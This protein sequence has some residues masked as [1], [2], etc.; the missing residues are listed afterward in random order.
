[1]LQI[2]CAINLESFVGE[3]NQ[4]FTI[5]KRFRLSPDFKALNVYRKFMFNNL[6]RVKINVSNINDLLSDIVRLWN[7]K[8]THY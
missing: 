2:D 7:G 5:Y 4:D 1:M 8:L 3:R 6:S